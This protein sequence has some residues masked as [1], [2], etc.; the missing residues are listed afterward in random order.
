MLINQKWK[1][2]WFLAAALAW[3]L[4]FSV[5][6]IL[7]FHLGPSFDCFWQAENSCVPVNGSFQASTDHVREDHRFPT[8]LHNEVVYHVAPW[9]AEIG[10]WLSG[11]DSI[12]KEVNIVEVMRIVDVWKLHLHG[13]D[14]SLHLH[15]NSCTANQEMMLLENH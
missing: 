8:G 4:A 11:C 13:N 14:R 7:L 9:K 6:H 15:I 10:R 3:I 1:C 5:V 12:I 2:S